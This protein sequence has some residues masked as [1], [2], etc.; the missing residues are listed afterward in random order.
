MVIEPRCNGVCDIDLRFDGGAEMR[1]T[2][3][4]R[5]LGLAGGLIWTLVWMR[6]RRRVSAA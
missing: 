1:V 3:A 6:R 5:I 4:L 2:Y